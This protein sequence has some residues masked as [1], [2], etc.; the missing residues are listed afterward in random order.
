MIQPNLTAGFT[1]STAAEARQET[2]VSTVS[3]YGCT[4]NDE[5]VDLY[6]P[7]ISISL[8]PPDRL[9]LEPRAVMNLLSICSTH[10]MATTSTVATAADACSAA[11]YRAA[12][13]RQTTM[14]MT[15]TTM[16][17][18]RSGG[19]ALRRHRTAAEAVSP[20]LAPPRKTRSRASGI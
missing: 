17:G 4:P 2:R 5:G 6:V 7:K 3:A 8:E 12:T 15:T 19:V 9:P 11:G 20:A 16:C 10:D 1:P 18:G 14:K 13:K